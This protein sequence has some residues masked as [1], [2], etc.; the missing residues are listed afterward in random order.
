M[1]DS[2]LHSRALINCRQSTKVHQQ[3]AV[4]AE[5]KTVYH[6]STSQQE[7]S[8]LQLQIVVVLLNL[9]LLNGVFPSIFHMFMAVIF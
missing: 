9:M 2:I 3:A 1:D 7:L 4:T 5:T 6:Q 8:Y